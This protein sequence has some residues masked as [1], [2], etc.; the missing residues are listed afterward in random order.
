M[1]CPPGSICD[2]SRLVCRA[3]PT[4]DAGTECPEETLFLTETR[5]VFIVPSGI[6]Y[7]H[8]K[9]W[10][11]G[12]NGEQGCMPDGT[13]PN[14]G[15]GGFSEAAFQVTPEEPL[16]IFVGQRAQLDIT[17]DQTRRYGFPASGGGGLSGVFRGPDPISATD[18][19]R[20]LIIAGGG[21][22]AGAPGCL[23][24]GAGDK[25]RHKD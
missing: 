19:D 12:A 5:E 13:E 10:G 18:S 6:E 3:D 16:I 2:P 22:S 15:P 4:G 1:D 7:M 9:A 21:G 14:G 17:D 11:S 23:P 8:V 25:R 24:G 20:A